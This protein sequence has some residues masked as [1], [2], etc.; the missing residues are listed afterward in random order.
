MK[1]I[2]VFCLTLSLFIPSS[3]LATDLVT[4]NLAGQMTI[5]IPGE[6]V[7]LDKN[8]MKTLESLVR[9]MVSANQIVV[10]GQNSYLSFMAGLYDDSG[11]KAKVI[12]RNYP[13]SQFTQRHVQNKQFL[14][15]FE[16]GLK[17]GAAKAA[18]AGGVKILSWGK[19]YKKDIAG[20]IA[21][22]NTYRRTAYPG[23]KGTFFVKLIRFFD[24]S[25]TFSITISY[26]ETQKDMLQPICTKI[27]ESVR[28]LQ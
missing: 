18:R 17:E 7:V 2:I 11:D 19:G 12:I 1:A 5:D 28:F 24:G 13:D 22:L 25:K 27:L 4:V 10:D 6:W 26:N 14:K 16:E 15:D 21:F 3:V 20:K 8:E 23:Q 9:Q